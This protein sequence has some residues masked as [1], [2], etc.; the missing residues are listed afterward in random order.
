M[1]KLDRQVHNGSNDMSLA[2]HCNGCARILV[3]EGRVV[4]ATPPAN[5]SPL[6]MTR[7]DAAMRVPGPT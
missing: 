5:V 7:T 3:E 2:T 4:G 6:A 1:M